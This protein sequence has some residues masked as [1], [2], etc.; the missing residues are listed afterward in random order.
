MAFPVISQALTVTASTRA[1]R[2][3]EPGR[4]GR[5]PRAGAS[6]ASCSRQPGMQGRADP[7]PP[8]TPLLR[9][10]AAVLSAT[11]RCRIA[12]RKTGEERRGSVG[13]V[14]A[15]IL[16]GASPDLELEQ[17]PGG[18]GHAQLL[19]RQ[20]ALLLRAPARPR[21]QGQQQQQHRPHVASA[22]SHRE[23][24]RASAPRSRERRPAPRRRRLSR[25]CSR[26]C[27]APGCAAAGPKATAPG[28]VRTWWF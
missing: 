13:P 9:T 24:P 5:H 28:V 27:P 11:S 12:E 25:D 15:A 16:P 21:R 3:T 14:R 18:V 26:S 17:R 20:A 4:E 19:G 2:R 7:R 10:S 6:A 23:S 1:P 8:R 22:S